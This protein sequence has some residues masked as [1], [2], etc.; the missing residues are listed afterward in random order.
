MKTINKK[1]PYLKQLDITGNIYEAFRPDQVLTHN[2]LN[3]LVNY[4][5]DQDRLTRIHLSGVGIG[6]G[7]NITS[8]GNDHIEIGQGFGI[9]TCL[10]YTSPSP[11]DA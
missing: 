5:E 6:G 7:M 4:F 2:N 1:D 9:T 3:K 10:L 11:R 8:F